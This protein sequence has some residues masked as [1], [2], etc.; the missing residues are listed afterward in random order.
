M[1][2]NWKRERKNDRREKQN[3]QDSTLKIEKVK[4][5]AKEEGYSLR[6]W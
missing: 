6:G 2:P 3:E 5:K 1:K 4:W